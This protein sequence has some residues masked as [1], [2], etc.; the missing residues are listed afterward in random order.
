MVGRERDESGQ[1]TAVYTDN[2]FLSAVSEHEPASTNE[3]A[4][5]V[6]CVHQNADYRLRQLEERDEVRSKKVGRELVWMLT[7]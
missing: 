6:G 2:D 5:A 1:Y 4:N 7:E 3:V